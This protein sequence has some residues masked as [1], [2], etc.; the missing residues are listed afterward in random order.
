VGEDRG[1]LPGREEYVGRTAS[2]NR[3][4]VNGV[5]WVL[6]SGARWYDLP[7]WYGK[8][9]SVHK[10]RRSHRRMTPLNGKVFRYLVNRS[11]KELLI[12]THRAVI[13][14]I[15]EIVSNI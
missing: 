7:E 12:R 15:H 11:S 14:L 9:K 13:E 3:L 6:R 5:S 4:F 10:A 2:D 8:Y 1:I